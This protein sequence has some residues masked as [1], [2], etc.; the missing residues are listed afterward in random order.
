[1]KKLNVVKLV[2]VLATVVCGLFIFTACGKSE[3]A[4]AIYG[5]SVNFEWDAAKAKTAADKKGKTVDDIEYFRAFA[6]TN[7]KH[8]GS[9]ATM[10]VNNANTILV[11]NAKQG[12]TPSYTVGALGYVFGLAETTP[13]DSKVTATVYDLFGNAKEEKVKFYDF[14]VVGVRWNVTDK[15]A[16]WYIEW[17]K[18]CPNTVFGYTTAADFKDATITNPTAN[19]TD[20]IKWTNVDN[21]TLDKDN[22]LKV[23]VKVIADDDGGYTV[24]L[25]DGAGTTEKATKKI[26]QSVTGHKTKAENN[27]N[28]EQFLIGRYC[29][30]P[31]G[32]S[33]KGKIEY[34]NIVRSRAGDVEM[35]D[36]ALPGFVGDIH[37]N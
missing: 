34:S 16:Q 7:T 36:L 31:K 20:I 30:V 26:V 24:K 14:G 15:K 17:A 28:L 12:T 5:D 11:E 3:G 1:M 23:V 35:I 13:T 10:T 8:E 32:S 22:N 37:E 21:I 18:N 4:G 19:P 29:S 27:D 6:T 2:A 33:L 9:E 25:Y